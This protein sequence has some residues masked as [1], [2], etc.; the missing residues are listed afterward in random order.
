MASQSSE[1]TLAIEYILFPESVK[2]KLKIDRK[3]A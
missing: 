3:L 1:Y 2:F